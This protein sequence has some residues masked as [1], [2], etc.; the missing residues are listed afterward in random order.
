MRRMSNAHKEATIGDNE[1]RELEDVVESAR[2][3]ARRR[4][5]QGDPFEHASDCAFRRRGYQCNCAVGHPAA[6]NTSDADRIAAR[7]K[8]E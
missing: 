3:A 2:I 6:D 1:R 8:G 5:K 4:P 7:G